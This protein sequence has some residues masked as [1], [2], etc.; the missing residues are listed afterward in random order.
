M[1]YAAGVKFR[2]VSVVFNLC[3]G[4]CHYWWY[5]CKCPRSRMHSVDY[6]SLN[7]TITSHR[8][9]CRQLHTQAQSNTFSI[10]THFSEFYVSLYSIILHCSAHKCSLFSCPDHTGVFIYYVVLFKR[11]ISRSVLILTC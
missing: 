1:R 3:H 9:A 11:I 8:I 5:C 7:C 2:T 6:S 10:Y 4:L